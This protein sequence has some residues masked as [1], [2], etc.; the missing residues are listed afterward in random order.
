MFNHYKLDEKKN[1]YT[2][3]YKTQEIWSIWEKTIS[4]I[5]QISFPSLKFLFSI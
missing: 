2:I 3:I 5:K 4:K 1:P